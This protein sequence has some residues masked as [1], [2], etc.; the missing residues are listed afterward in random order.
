LLESLQN[1]QP[2]QYCFTFADRQKV[3]EFLLTCSQSLASAK[4]EAVNEI[5]L[6]GII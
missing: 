3:L 4:V 6:E 5:H 2:G 1:S